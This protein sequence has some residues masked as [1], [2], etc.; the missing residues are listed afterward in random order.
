METQGETEE[1]SLPEGSPPPT[2]SSPLLESGKLSSFVDPER[3]PQTFPCNDPQDRKPERQV[4][5]LLVG[6][7][8]VGK[9]TLGNYLFNLGDRKKPLFAPSSGPMS[10]GRQE[11]VSKSFIVQ[12]EG[13]CSKINLIDTPGLSHQSPQVDL[14][15]MIGYFPFSPSLFCYLLSLSFP[16]LSSFFL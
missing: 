5:L 7:Q 4:N 3:M 14:F 9:S 2:P 16:L 12:D 15:N 8:G 11:T 10:N 6:N 13:V 1:A